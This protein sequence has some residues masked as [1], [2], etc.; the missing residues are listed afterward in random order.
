MPGVLY[1]VGV[2]PGDPELITLKAARIIRKCPIIVVPKSG[3]GERVALSIARQAVPELVDKQLVELDMPMTRDQALLRAC[4]EKAAE[5][6]ATYL[7]GGADVAFLTLGDPC[8]YS[9]Y[10]YV[11]RLIR[12]MG[13]T[14]EII[15][16]VPSF[17]AVSAKL[18]DA[19]VETSQPLHIIP[20]SYGSLR[21]NLAMPGT[22]VLMKSGK[23]FPDVK[24]ALSDLGLTINANMVVSCGMP[25]EKV[26][27]T[28]ENV[29]EVPGYFTIIVV[30]ENESM[31]GK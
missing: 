17:C 20:G 4:H 5:T 6:I 23:A 24:A 1:G 29:S 31:G 27:G 11:D 8:I 28:L 14:A 22:K 21:E 2:G 25:D 3:D 7:D 13:H 26:Y 9:T 10:I 18:G 30:K 19:L 16:G 15:S 12:R